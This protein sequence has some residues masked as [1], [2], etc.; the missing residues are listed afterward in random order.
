MPNY[1]TVRQRLDSYGR[2]AAVLPQLQQIYAQCQAVAGSINTYQA[3]T[4][5][6]FNTAINSIFAPAERAELAAMLTQINAL[7]SDWTTE[8]GALLEASPSQ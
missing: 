2:A 3:G 8:H 4:D 6:D 7:V 5:A 1:T